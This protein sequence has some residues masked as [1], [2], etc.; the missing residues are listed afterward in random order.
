VSE[1][2][3]D[4]LSNVLA[5]LINSDIGEAAVAWDADRKSALETYG[6][7]NSWDASAVT[8]MVGIIA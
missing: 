1:H 4:T 5:A 7:I 3:K 6:Y 2:P 8:S